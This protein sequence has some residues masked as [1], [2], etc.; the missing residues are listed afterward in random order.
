MCTTARELLEIH[1]KSL[2]HA[3]L[4]YRSLINNFPKKTTY[5]LNVLALG[6]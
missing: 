4:T 2:V 3:I 1:I 5:E 6:Y